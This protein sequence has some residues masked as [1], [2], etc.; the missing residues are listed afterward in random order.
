MKKK[1][2]ISFSRNI[3][4]AGTFDV[5]AAG[6][7]PAAVAVLHGISSFRIPFQEEYFK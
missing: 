3:P 7:I 2:M 1:G 6:G 5:I 4:A